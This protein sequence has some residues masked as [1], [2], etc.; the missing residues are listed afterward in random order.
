MLNV[1]NYKVKKM[2][3][4][5]ISKKLETDMCLRRKLFCPTASEMGEILGAVYENREMK[6][7]DIATAI[8]IDKNRIEE[9]IDELKKH[10]YLTEINGVYSITDKAR[11]FI[12]S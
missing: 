3:Y 6:Y 8:K 11:K 2:R 1:V 9:N 7:S 12:E 10:G 4:E 5:S